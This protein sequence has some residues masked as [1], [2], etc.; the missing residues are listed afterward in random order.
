M[1]SFSENLRDYKRNLNLTSTDVAE[2]A[3]LTLTTEQSLEEGDNNFDAII[4]L[5]VK[6]GMDYSTA[7]SDTGLEQNDPITI[8]STYPSAFRR[9]IS[10]TLFTALQSRANRRTEDDP[11]FIWSP[12]HATLR[13]RL[14]A[15]SA[16]LSAEHL[17]TLQKESQ[18][19]ISA[20]SF[21]ELLASLMFSK[22]P[23]YNYVV[24][25][26]TYNLEFRDIGKSLGVST[27]TVAKWGGNCYGKIA[28]KH[29]DRFIKLAGDVNKELFVSQILKA[30]DFENRPCIIPRTANPDNSHR[31]TTIWHPVVS[32][33]L[34]A[35]P[36]LPL[37]E[38]LI[39]TEELDAS[40][41]TD[42]VQIKVT[43]EKAMKLYQSLDAENKKKVNKYI[44]ELFF[45]QA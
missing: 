6:L 20:E 18:S 4:Q 9:V 25:K 7:Y 33:N 36:D 30:A 41:V 1:R 32:D 28:N 34:D 44:A 45:D 27:S 22:I 43:D 29:L 5:C 14:L 12:F 39:M 40:S 3:D 26:S 13:G 15:G 35:F 10:K 17:N 24:A 21:L 11:D 37:D 16:T 42:A 8:Y 38:P 19:I 23:N 31:Q 2:L